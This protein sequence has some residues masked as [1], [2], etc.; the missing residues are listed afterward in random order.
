MEGEFRQA[1]IVEA[2]LAKLRPQTGIQSAMSYAGGVFF[3]EHE[4]NQ[5]ATVLFGLPADS[6]AS[7]MA[8]VSK[9]RLDGTMD[10]SDGGIVTS[11]YTAAEMAVYA[12]SNVTSAVNRFRVASDI[13]DE[14][15]RHEAFKLIK[16]RPIEAKLLGYTAPRQPDIL[17]TPR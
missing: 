7:Y 14:K 16:L 8:K 13:S 3:L 15:K 4:G 2:T 9:H 17:P 1:L 10:L 11:D 6:A 5:S 12:S